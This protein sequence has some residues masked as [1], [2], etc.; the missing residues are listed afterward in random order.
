LD[1]IRKIAATLSEQR[2]SVESLARHLDTS[3]RSLEGIQTRFM[4]RREER[5]SY[6]ELLTRKEA[7][8]QAYASWQVTC[9]ELERWEEIAAAFV[10]TTASPGTAQRDQICTWAPG[11]GGGDA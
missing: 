2:R 9:Q 10:N 7:I 6:N 11:P 1:N 3:R 8:H 4:A 5:Q